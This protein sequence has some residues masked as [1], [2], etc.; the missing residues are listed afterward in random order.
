MDQDADKKTQRNT[1]EKEAPFELIEN[2]IR[3]SSV[4][5]LAHEFRTRLAVIKGAIDNV[6][7]GVFGDVNP[8][9]KKSLIIAA[10]GVERMSELVEDLM[11]SLAPGRAQ[12]RINRE[13][14]P[15][16]EIVNHA[17]ESIHSLAYKEG[18]NMLAH[19]PK[20]APRVYCDPIKIEQVLLN[21]FRNSIK[22]TPRG[23][24]ITI[25]IRAKNG[26]VEVVVS[27]SGV[28]MPRAKLATLFDAP[29]PDRLRT[30]DG[31]YRTS[32]L[33]LIIVKDIL[34]AHGSE[35]SVKS[36]ISVGT[37]FTFTLPRAK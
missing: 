36:E 35:I 11:A 29:S 7:D 30:E 20:R 17:I 3:E 10:E 24:T 4:P 8:G 21:L 32:G 15:I 5:K 16:A 1:N 6:T 23:G 2:E 28:G 9:Q 27:D 14:V 34:D 25:R 26:D 13:N 19:I 33:G 22:F 18:I 31:G 12:I 37:S